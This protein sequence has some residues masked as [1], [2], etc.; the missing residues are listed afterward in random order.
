M[1]KSFLTN[2]IAAAVFL[3]TYLSPPFTWQ[4]YL[5]QA[6]LFALSGALT[7]WLAI[8][9]LF[10]KV[11]GFY[12]SGIIPLHFE[13]FKSGI[14]TLIMENFFTESNFAQMTENTL[15][16]EIPVDWI[17]EQVDFEKV[18][19][20]FIAVIKE[21]PFGG[22]L[23]LV[24]GEQALQPLKVPFQKEFQG[25]LQELLLKI[26]TAALLKKEWG[27][28]EFKP[29]V[30]QMINSRLAELTPGQVK[31]IID[32]MIREHLGWLVVWGG[33]FGAIIGLVS[34]VVFQ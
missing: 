4:V 8:Y 20:R 23:G 31:Q 33:V 11:P 10:E 22:M 25:Q 28:E 7:N 16:T 5:S 27:F 1:N 2:L 3:I 34:A 32:Q 9:M 14:R 30:E 19:D 24:G 13:E 6:S 26:D 17:V 12:G 15:P 29:K 18:F 21:S